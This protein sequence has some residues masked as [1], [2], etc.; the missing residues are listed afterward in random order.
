MEAPGDRPM[1]VMGESTGLDTVPLMSVPPKVPEY[2]GQ[3]PL[4]PVTLEGSVPE[5]SLWLWPLMPSPSPGL[6]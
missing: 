2:P 4:S 6:G 3:T 1:G 5:V